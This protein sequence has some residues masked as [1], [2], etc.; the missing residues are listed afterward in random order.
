MW[1]ELPSL[2]CGGSGRG[3]RHYDEFMNVLHNRRFVS[4]KGEGST[5]A[6]VAR[7]DTRF[8]YRSSQ[9]AQK[10]TPK[11]TNTSVNGWQNNSREAY[12]S[13]MLWRE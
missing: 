7:V 2:G 8:R 10:K 4:E 1:L 5:L 11:H 9:L 13:V 12:F 6:N 3:R